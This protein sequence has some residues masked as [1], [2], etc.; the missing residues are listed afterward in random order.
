MIG[1][2]VFFDIIFIVGF[3][4]FYTCGGNGMVLEKIFFKGLLDIEVYNIVLF[5]IIDK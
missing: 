3:K 4:F 2:L 5:R 1:R